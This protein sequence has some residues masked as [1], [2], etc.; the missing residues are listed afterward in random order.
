MREPRLIP[1]MTKVTKTQAVAVKLLA[2][3]KKLT[4]SS[5]IHQAIVKALREAA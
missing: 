3:A 4:K 5:W 2:K 1:M